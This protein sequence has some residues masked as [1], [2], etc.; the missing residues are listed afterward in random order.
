MLL[1]VE[2]PKVTKLLLFI[3]T[4]VSSWFKLASIPI[5]FLMLILSEK[6]IIE[7]DELQVSETHSVLK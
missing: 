4:I 3:I 1:G 5:L 7:R 2:S 6:Y